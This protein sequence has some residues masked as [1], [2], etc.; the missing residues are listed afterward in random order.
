MNKIFLYK[1]SYRTLGNLLI[2]E[3]IKK[4]ANKIVLLGVIVFLF[5]CSTKKNTVVTRNYHNITS[6]YNIYFNASEIKREGHKKIESSYREDFNNILPIDIYSQ[7]EVA[8]R[9]LPDMDK[10]IKKCSKVI[11]MH[12]ITAKPKRKSRGN[13]SEKQKEFYKK[14]E[15]N[16]WIDDSYLLMG[17]AYFLKNDQFPAIQNFEY[18]IRQYPEDGLK[19]E[20]TLWLAKSHLAL[21]DYDAS[22]EILDR[23]EAA[24]DL[25]DELR[26][27]LAAVR[28]DWNLRQEQYSDA[29]AYLSEAIPLIKDKNQ[30]RRYTYITAQLLERQEDFIQASLKYEEVLK[31]NP[32]YSMAFNAKI[33][34]A[35]LYEGDSEK[36]KEIRKQL[37]KMLRDDKNLEFLDQ[38]YYA[39]A[40]LDMKEGLVEDAIENYKLSAQSS[41]GNLHQQSLSYLALGKIYYS[42]NDYLPA[43]T[44]YDSCMLMLPEIF[45]DRENIMNL[46]VSL[47]TLAENLRMINRED[48]LQAIAAMP[49]SERDA[50]ID[51]KIKEAVEAEEERMRME[52]EERLNG[53]GQGGFRM[54]GGGP[55]GPGGRLAMAPGGPGGGPGGMGG[56]M[57]MQGGQGQLGGAASSWY[58][59]NPTTL[60]YGQGEFTKNWG[61]R[62]LEDNWRRTNKGISSALGEMSTEGEEGDVMTPTFKSNAGQF[63]PTQREY[64]T[65]DL[66]IN[67]TLLGESHERI[68]AALFNVGKV[69]KDEL[70][71]PDEG[72]D[73]F[74]QLV[75]RYPGTD[76]KLFTYYNL[77]MVYDEQGNSEQS[78]Y[79]KNLILDQFPDS[80]SAK[81]ISNPNYFREIE[82]EKMKAI[83]YYKETYDDFL[84]GQYEKVITRSEYADTAFGINPIRDKFGLLKVLSVGALDPENSVVMV[85]RLNELLF[86]YPQS[87]VKEM[88]N[89]LLDYYT[90]GSEEPEAP[91]GPTKDGLSIGKV[92]GVDE[93]VNAEYIYEAESIHFYVAVLS[94]RSQDLNRLSFNISNF[95]IENYDQDFFEVTTSPMNNDLMVVIVKNFTSAKAGMD[96][97]YALLADPLVFSEFEER[98]FRHFI[99]S[100][101]NYNLFSKNQNVFKYIQFFNENYLEAN[102]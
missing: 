61:R 39:I 100:R 13:P 16:K 68:Q 52:E 17:Q 98:D 28:A 50:L 41:V 72:I 76:R 63:S 71:K 8:S 64:Y 93:D 18:V 73:Y 99:I 2:L 3:L 21:K 86:K 78:D 87:E 49:E 74:K 44:Y 82:E 9:L 65:A 35:R 59:Y 58:F 24:T 48:S 89:V 27:Q 38:V 66:P 46:G 95:N 69:F 22:V 85:N 31:L 90:K 30:V 56:S 32:D 29:I 70:G 34:R 91:K 92:D 20:A 62:K 51:K 23:L 4:L 60:S 96:Y 94:R 5:G 19:N 36:G 75:E 77:Y 15:F 84:N 12:S 10:V 81:I 40:E 83:G 67:D 53:R 45:P 14:N 7:R 6:L 101:K 55:G 37:Q 102:K 47:N 88:V 42:R 11:T 33:N 43:Q 79:Y 26:G 1:K 57:G 25:N 80:R 54:A 97:Y